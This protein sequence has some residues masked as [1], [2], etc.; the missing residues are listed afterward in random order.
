MKPRQRPHEPRHAIRAAGTHDWP[1]RRRNARERILDDMVDR[2][3]KE[4][5]WSEFVRLST[6]YGESA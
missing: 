5:S 6:L 3:E 1:S 4:R 2:L